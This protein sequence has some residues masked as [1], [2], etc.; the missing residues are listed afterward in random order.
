MV[1]KELSA[2]KAHVE[3]VYSSL[4][5]TITNHLVKGDS[6]AL[7]DFGIFTTS[8]RKARTGRN[9]KTGA[10][11]QIAAKKVAGFRVGK[12]LKEAVA[13]SKKK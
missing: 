10:K 11:L 8:D 1:A 3:K 5:G 2:T 13:G 4:F 9:P 6:V 7:P 12:K